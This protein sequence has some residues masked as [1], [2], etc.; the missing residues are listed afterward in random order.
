MINVPVPL[1]VEKDRARAVILAL[2]RPLLASRCP[3]TPPGTSLLFVRPVVCWP[4]ILI[5]PLITDRGRDCVTRW[6]LC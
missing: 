4:S 6:G 5:R 3:D 1:I 2:L